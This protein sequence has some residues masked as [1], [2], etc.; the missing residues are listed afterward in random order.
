L[1][2]SALF[3]RRPIGTT[4]LAIGLFL[5]GMV[6]YWH[7]PV[8]SLPNADL[9]AV[10]VFAMLPGADPE[11]MAASVA[12]PLERRIGEIAGVNELTSISDIGSSS[13]QVQFDLSRSA[14]DAA[15]DVQ[16]AINA[17]QADLPHT[18][19]RRPTIRKSNTASSPIMILAM[20]SPTRRATDLF[21]LGD[22]I[23]KTRIS[24]V[25][26]VAEVL[27][28]GAQTPALRVVADP[29]RLETRSL[30][31][32]DV[33]TAI[34]QANSLV[35]SGVLDGPDKSTTVV[36]NGQITK[37]ADYAALVVKVKGGDVVRIADVASVSTGTSNR[38]SAGYYNGSPAVLFIVFKTAEA[39][40]VKTVDGIYGLMPEL[41]RLLPADVQLEVL[42][43]RTQ[44]IRA[45]V[46]DVQKTLIASIALVMLVVFVF[47]RRAVPTLAAGAAI[48]L[49]LAGSA[50]LMWLSGYSLNNFSLV[51]LTISVGFVVDDAIVTIENCYRNMEAGLRPFEAAMEGARQIGFTVISITVSL[52]AAFIPL[53]FMGDVM[54]R[55]LRE[56]SW[57]LTYSILISAAISLTVTPMICGRFIRGL[58]RP[59]ETWLDRRLEPFFEALLARYER[60]LVYALHHRYLMVAV[61]FAA[62]V[63][64]VLLFKTLPSALVPQGDAAL[65]V[66]TASAAPETSFD[67]LDELQKKI[68]ALIAKDPGVSGLA[69]SFGT[70]GFGAPNE[71]DFYASLKPLDERKTTVLGVIARLRQQLSVIKGV[72]FSLFPASE[73]QFGGRHSRSKFQVTIWSPDLNGIATW[74]PQ[75][76]DR[77]KRL[78][79]IVDV[80]SDRESGGQQIMLTIDRIKAAKYGVAVKDIDNAL[81][82]A[83][84]QRAVSTIYDF[85]N[86]YNVILEA[87]AGLQQSPQ[88]L[89]RI[90][91]NSAS[92]KPVPLLA[93]TSV[94]VAGRPLSINHTGQFPAAT[95]SFDTAKDVSLGKV[96]PGIKQIVQG[97]HMPDTVHVDF[98]GETLALQKHESSAGLL[99][100][101][102]L[103]AVYLVLGILYED[104]V[105]PLTIISTLPTAGFGALLTLS[106]TKQEL[107]VVALIGI[108][109]L[110]GIV[111]KNGILLIDFALEAQRTRGLSS[112]EAIHK[113]CVERFRP[114]LMTT[115]AAM[116]GALPL[117]LA[118]G[119]GSELRSPLGYAIFGGLA[120]SQLLTI[121]TTPAIYLLLERLRV[122]L[123]SR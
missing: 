107:S 93:I 49:S 73:L 65:I 122:R 14:D 2:P 113:A 120:V 45:S 37:P 48:P 30:G 84:S 13:V 26:G 91:V 35:P 60:S 92:G 58:P 12:A 18:L 8:A 36:T 11:T 31:L 99:I 72:D 54:G 70:S 15:R 87:E 94:S 59:R 39:N 111:K 74:L 55:L 63:L 67:A 1:N 56:F 23:V 47:L 51:A 121:Y 104:L 75:I 88:G 19:T 42:N 29:A 46:S 10:R 4:L 108:I 117:I 90:N 118:S 106:V 96:L 105:H 7:L 81:G 100:I 9:P 95:I 52:I 82:D 123:F 20:T 22:L 21:D 102:A 69:V 40:V 38:L 41:R 114:I 116:F 80:N 53:L 97:L 68:G 79:G 110:I 112:E 71:V 101:S 64:S 109:L 32:E 3:I 27:L 61:T 103:I 43:D 85:R 44:A 50:V 16:A 98:A 62:L 25:Q 17:A 76:Q 86:Q 57:T 66:G 77:M 33:R 24:Q 78:E 6:A 34:T 115:L 89:A 28:G 83:F 5:A 119:P